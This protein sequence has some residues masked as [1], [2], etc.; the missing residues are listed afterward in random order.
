MTVLDLLRATD[1]Q[2]IDGVLYNGNATTRT[3][4]NNVYSLV[5]QDGDIG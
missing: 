1:A 2:A 5:N 4:A 3:T